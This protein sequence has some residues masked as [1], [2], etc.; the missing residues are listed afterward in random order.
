MSAIWAKSCWF[1]KLSA[2]TVVKRNGLRQ[3]WVD[4]SDGFQSLG[5]E[6]TQN[7]L[8]RGVNGSD[9]NQIA[10]GVR[11]WLWESIKKRVW[12]TIF[13]FNNC[14]WNG[15]IVN[16]MARLSLER[17]LMRTKTYKDKVDDAKKFRL[18]I[19]QSRL[20]IGHLQKYQLAIGHHEKY[21]LA[22]GNWQQYQLP[23]GTWQ[24]Y[25]LKIGNQL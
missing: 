21:Q 13:M 12:L 24:Q 7:F 19:G 9:K 11:N 1:L 17:V 22:I 8:G 16:D 4:P 25:Q 18:T 6:K 20:K 5:R 23:I 15:N 2:S 3:N 14:S 10:A